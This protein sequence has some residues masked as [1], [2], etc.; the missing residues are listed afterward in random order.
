VQPGA[1][2]GVEQ[3]AEALK[4]AQGDLAAVRAAALGA[5]GTSDRGFPVARVAAEDLQRVSGGEGAAL[6]E[7][8][9]FV[10]Q[11]VFTAVGESQFQ[12][13]RDAFG[14]TDPAA[15]VRLD[16]RSADGTP[17]PPWLQFDAV[18]GTFRGT[19]PGGAPTFLEIILT[20]RDEEG[21]E[22]SIAFTLELGVKTGEAEPV[23]ADS[24]RAPAEPRARADF[25]DEDPDKVAVDATGA[26]AGEAPGKDKVE[27]LKHARAGA[28]PFAE[29]IRA[30][31]TA[32]DPLLA[33]ILG[34]KD[35]QPGRSRL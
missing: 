33:K 18:S 16:A 34:T 7:Q 6:S 1:G 12:I 19:P 10:Y 26:D 5:A 8:R 27:K 21:R 35:K 3:R 14:H 9:L 30:A 29:Q 25:D 11:G 17:L 20:A 31:Q 24:D 22:A 4:L 2:L 15:I 13:P 23:K 32:R 28:A